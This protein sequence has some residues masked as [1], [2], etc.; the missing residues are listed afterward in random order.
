MGKNIEEI[1]FPYYSKSPAHHWKAINKNSS[2]CISYMSDDDFDIYKRDYLSES[3]L[4]AKE[5]KKEDFD[6]QM[7][8]VLSLVKSM[9]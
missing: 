2:L 3:L 4:E 9:I 5:C 1:E 8:K 7:D 6:K